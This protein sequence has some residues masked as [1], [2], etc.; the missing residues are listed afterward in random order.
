MQNLGVKVKYGQE[1]GRN[2]S[3][4]NLRE[5]GN[6]AIFLGF[7][8]PDPKSSVIFKG[9]NESQG[10]YTS[11]EFLP[12]VAAASKA[13]MCSC[14]SALP[15]LHGNV[16]VLGAG[17]T[18]FDCATS[19]IRCGARRV[20]VAFRKGVQ[21]IRAVPEE[22]DAAKDERCEFMPFLNPEKVYTDKEGKAWCY[23]MTLFLIL[24]SIFF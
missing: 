6:E 1:M 15:A 23:E 14:K 17:D 9:L 13:G 7:G 21:N 19:A 10:F 16:V 11:K 3:V 20:F 22:A 12:K 8:L 5:D 24:I 18:A 2:I 4:D